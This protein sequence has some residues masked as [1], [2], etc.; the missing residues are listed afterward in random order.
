MTRILCSTNFQVALSQLGN[1]RLFR[2]KSWLV[3]TF[4]LLTQFEICFTWENRTFI[5]SPPWGVSVASLPFQMIKRGADWHT[6]KY[7]HSSTQ[8]RHSKH[9][10]RAIKDRM[11]PTQDSFVSLR[12][13][14][15]MQRRSRNPPPREGCLQWAPAP[16]SSYLTPE[17]PK[18]PTGPFVV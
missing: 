3:E 18:A 15:A 11:G 9:P 8:H 13:L 14:Q 4:Q 2:R 7:A 10:S 16:G 6:H 12:G 1:I 5:L 17:L